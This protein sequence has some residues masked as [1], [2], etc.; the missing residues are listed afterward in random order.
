M[1]TVPATRLQSIDFLRG[2]AA[3]AVV[4][5]HVPHRG[6]NWGQPPDALY[7]LFLPFDFGWL[8]VT[9]FIVLSGFCIH[10]N[11]LR[12]AADQPPDR[13]AVNWG[14]FWKRRF[15]R[16][17]P[18]YLVV[19]LL[20]VLSLC[21]VYRSFGN[22][23]SLVRRYFDA[24][25]PNWGYLLADV[26]T[27]I[28]M[29]HNLVAGFGMGLGNG[30]LWSLGMEEQ[31][32]AM[33][34][35]YL[36]LRRRLPR[37]VV[38]L[39]VFLLS[40]LGWQFWMAWGPPELNLGWFA[41]GDWGL[42]PLNYWF[43]WI[44]GSLAA[45]AYFGRLTLPTWCRSG[46]VGGTLLL[47]FIGTHPNTWQPLTGTAAPSVALTA[48]LGLTGTA[49][50]AVRFAFVP[51]MQLLSPVACFILMNAAVARE[52]RHGPSAAR[53]TRI[54]AYLGLFSYS[55]YLTHV[56]IITLSEKLFRFNYQFDLTT[57][58]M[59]YGVCVPLCVLGG[60]VFFQAVERHF[61]VRKPKPIMATAAPAPAAATRRAA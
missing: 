28:F 46:W 19:V 5:L 56:P 18:P 38:V 39:G 9:L 54:F 52:V 53:S 27:H 42:W 15:M 10:A 48:G 29:V 14:R 23:H 26:G 57:I 24:S 47:V 6:P 41:L 45:E 16:L 22:E 33:Y 2:V 34:F 49:A 44:L 36:A 55:L 7:W 37:W 51:V 17:Y 59:R 20:S 30:P 61:L 4:F 31:L 13:F 58:L 43:A 60:W 11:T 1:A 8:G 3:L 35:G 21:L 32:Y 40:G 50:A 25:G 12:D